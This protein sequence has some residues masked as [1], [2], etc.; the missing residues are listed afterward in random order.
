MKTT[1]FLGISNS[2][3][4]LQHVRFGSFSFSSKL[5]RN[6]KNVY[7]SVYKNEDAYLEFS[8]QCPLF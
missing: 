7:V 2:N 6:L 1:K 4:I 5:F 8:S 3:E